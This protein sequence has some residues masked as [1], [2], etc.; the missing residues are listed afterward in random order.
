MHWDN[1]PHY[2]VGFCQW[3]KSK[4]KEPKAGNPH[5]CV[6]IKSRVF[7]IIR[8]DNFLPTGTVVEYDSMWPE[9]VV[10]PYKTPSDAWFA[11]A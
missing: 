11:K 10:N 7:S 8:K 3:T 9:D 2:F 1:S 5:G 6:D 4:R